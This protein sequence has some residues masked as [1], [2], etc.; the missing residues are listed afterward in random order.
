MFG[1]AAAV[2][3]SASA[4]ASAL[5]G[6]RTVPIAQNARERIREMRFPNVP[7]MTHTGWQVRFYDDILKDSKVVINLCKRS[8]AAPARP[9]RRI[10]WKRAGC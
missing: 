8:A 3:A 1:A 4:S 2:V 6:S 10:C 9:P 7:L 5:A